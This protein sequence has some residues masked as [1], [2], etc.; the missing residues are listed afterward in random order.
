MTLKL[1][2]FAIQTLLRQATRSDIPEI[3]RVRHAVKENRLTSRVISN[4]EVAHT[5]EGRGCGWVIEAGGRITAFAIGICDANAAETGSVWALFVDPDFEGLGQGRRLHDT[6]VNWLE[7]RGIRQL[8][9]STDAGTRAER[10]YEMSGW[11]RCGLTPEGE[12]RFEKLI[13]QPRA[14]D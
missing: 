14:S 3:Q 4:E 8:W 10:F 13:S 6:M 2:G 5:L 9:L 1:E 11:Q 7:S 12:V